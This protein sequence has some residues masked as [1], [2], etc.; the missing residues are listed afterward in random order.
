M[1][2]VTLHKIVRRHDLASVVKSGSLDVLATPI[3]IAWMEE[4][5]CACLELDPEQT[6]VGIF[7]QV[8]HDKASR[9]GQEVQVTATVTSIE[10]RKINFEVQATSEGEVIGKGIHSRFIVNAQKFMEKV[11]A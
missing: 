10:N 5:A 7:M 6:S 1:N 4:A 3:M 2:S 8:S 11:N 9:L